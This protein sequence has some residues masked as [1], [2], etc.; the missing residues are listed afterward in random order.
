MYTN[1][2][3]IQFHVVEWKA[4]LKNPQHLNIAGG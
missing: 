4:N 3:N 2:S 1:K